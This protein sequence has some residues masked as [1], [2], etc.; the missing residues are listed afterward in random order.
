MPTGVAHA[1][2]L[3]GAAIA[4]RS[5][6]AASTVSAILSGKRRPTPEQMVVLAAVFNVSP[7]PF[8]PAAAFS[9]PGK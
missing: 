7:A 9:R 6:I 8:L 4:R 2:G 1:N 3:T 5:G